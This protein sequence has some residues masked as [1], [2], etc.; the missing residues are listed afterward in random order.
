[1]NSPIIIYTYTKPL[2]FIAY[3]P[4]AR[5]DQLVKLSYRAF[6]KTLSAFF[7]DDCGPYRTRT[8]FRHC[9]R[10]VLA[11]YTIQPIIS[12]LRYSTIKLTTRYGGT[13]VEP[14][15][16]ACAPAG[17]RTQDPHIKFGTQESNL[18]FPFV[19]NE[20]LLNSNSKSVVLSTNWATSAYKRRGWDSN[21]RE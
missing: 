2:A 4:L 8:A 7:L 13:G 17:T 20:F 10:L 18:N 5:W 3:I 19:P 15:S 12:V 21:P 9:E 6:L 16:A 14:I 11:N 1:M